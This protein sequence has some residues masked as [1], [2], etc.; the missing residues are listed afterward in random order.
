LCA[1]RG[2]A[3]TDFVVAG[4]DKRR[5]LDALIDL[6]PEPPA[7]RSVPFAVGDT[8]SDAELLRA[9]RHAFVPAH[10]GAAARASGAT[11]TSRPYQRGLAQAVAWRLGHEPGGCRVCAAPPLE[12]D[13]QR[14]L[15]T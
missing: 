10:S 13:S 6:L 2:E 9:A 5:G 14:V 1:V 7:D 4:V 8:E 11:V 12:R 3:Q 15:L